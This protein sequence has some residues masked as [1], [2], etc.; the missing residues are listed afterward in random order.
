MCFEMA[1]HS[2][3]I[4]L[5]VSFEKLKVKLALCISVEGVNHTFFAPAVK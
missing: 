1:D 5:A 4:S 3:L 2:V